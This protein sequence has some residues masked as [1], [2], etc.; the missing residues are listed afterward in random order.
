MKNTSAIVFGGSGFIGTEIVRHLVHA[1]HMSVISADIVGP[2]DRIPT[3]EYR[4][5]D[6]R[7]PIDLPYQPDVIYNLAA[8]HRT[9]GHRESEYYDTNVSGALNVVRFGDTIQTKSLVFTSSIAVY[10]PSEEEINEAS[11]QR[12]NSAYGKS[13]AIAETIHRMWR[14]QDSTRKLV[15]VRPAVIFGR[16]EN[17]NFERLYRAMRSRYFVFPGRKD[18]IKACG[19][20]GELVR[21]IQWAVEEPDTELIFNFSYPERSTS[22][23]IVSAIARHAELQEP[24]LNMPPVVAS[25]VGKLQAH[26]GNHLFGRTMQRLA[27]LTTSNNV[28]P[29]VLVE[30]NYE[31]QTDLESGLALWISSLQS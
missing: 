31:F 5:C 24:S 21:A 7:E 19:Y 20:V 28:Y 27:K 1:E 23:D 16:G 18:T 25:L 29:G 13:K 11:P 30:R 4:Y 14:A 3:V 8:V 22:G 6:V 17:G 10:G 26:S 9:P 12:P 15:I 2:R